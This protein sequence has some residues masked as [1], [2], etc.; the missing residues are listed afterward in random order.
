M[1][2]IVDPVENV[3][4]Q[5]SFYT[6]QVLDAYAWHF[7]KNDKPCSIDELITYANWLGLNNKQPTK[8]E[9]IDF[10]LDQKICI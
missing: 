10:F 8:R 1:E 4:I 5:N 3:H 9:L 7:R 2:L 6:H